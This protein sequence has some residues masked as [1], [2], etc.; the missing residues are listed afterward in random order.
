[1]APEW[2]DRYGLSAR[3][4]RQPSGAAAV[5]QYVGQVGAD[6]IELLRAVY[7]TTAAPGGRHRATVEVL[8]QVWVQQYWYESRGGCGGGRRS[9]HERVR[10]GKDLRAGAPTRR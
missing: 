9:R 8:R 3:H 4:E 10:A 5:R 7:D 6:G 1:M 2:G